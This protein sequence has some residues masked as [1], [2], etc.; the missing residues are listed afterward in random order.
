MGEYNWAIKNR[1]KAFDPNLF[2]RKKTMKEE[3]QQFINRF[4]A[5]IMRIARRKLEHTNQEESEEGTDSNL[6]NG[7]LGPLAILICVAS[8]FGVTLL[9]SHNIF[10][11]ELF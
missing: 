10:I 8:T 3:L 7:L 1:R 9:P 5:Y 4:G 6:I 11:K 2:V